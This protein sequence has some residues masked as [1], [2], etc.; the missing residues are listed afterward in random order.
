[1][2]AHKG[3]GSMVPTSRRGGV[4][5]DTPSTMRRVWLPL[6]LLIACTASFA[7]SASAG[8]AHPRASTATYQPDAWIKLCGLSNGCTVGPKPPHPWH[9]NNTY[10]TTAFDQT[11]PIGLEEAEGVRFWI[12][13]QND[14]TQ[15]DTF[16]V[17]GCRGTPR[18][19]VNAVLVGFYKDTAWRPKHITDQFKAGTATFSVAPGNQ[20]GITLNIIATT[21]MKGVSYRCPVTITSRG[22]PTLKDTVAGIM[23]TT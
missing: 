18:F 22:D 5:A 20:V 9:G 8:S 6:V 10:N 21:T 2:G 4:S 17:Q 15:S 13:F 11:I 3:L 19:T 12:V 1:M 14:G 23:T 16:T 7:T